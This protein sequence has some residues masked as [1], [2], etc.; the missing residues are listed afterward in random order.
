MNILVLCTYPIQSPTHG[1]Q[2]RVRN[3]VDTYRAAGHTVQVAGVLGS[4]NYPAEPGFV[5]FPG[6]H[7][8]AKY[9]PNPFLMEDYAISQLFCFDD[10]FYTK[11][12]GLIKDKPDLV[13]IEQPWLFPFAKRYFT[14]NP[15]SVKIVYGQH[16]VEWRLK[17][18]ILS[19]YLGEDA[20]QR[21]ADLIKG[22]ELQAISGADVIVCVSENDALWLR[23]QTDSPIVLAPNG[24]NSWTVSTNGVCTATS[25][26]GGYRYALYCAS[27]HPPNMTGFF[28][29]LGGGFGSLK[30]DE[31]LVIAG[32]AG[33]SIAGDERVHSSPKLAEKIVVAGVVSQPCLEGLLDAAHC[34]ILPLTQG[35]G[36]N[37]KTAEALW[38]GKHIVATAV[39]MRGFESFIGA[40]GVHLADDPISFKQVLRDVMSSPP[41]CLSKDEIEM[42][43][44]VL[45]ESCLAPLHGMI[46]TLFRT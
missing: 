30:P 7:H 33:W 17:Q 13:H 46:N 23:S 9:I 36:T 39:A 12:A 32:G 20:A 6:A 41:L 40:S 26:T 21:G 3:I 29:L 18:S 37:L 43:K 2:I 14:E 24:V 10:V 1:G 27:A 25:I 38:S 15:R 8:L 35:G 22:V 4:D 44:V 11:L 31:K 34:I 16:N 5:R 19:S 42:R 45:W 28:D